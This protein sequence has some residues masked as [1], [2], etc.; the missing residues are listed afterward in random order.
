A[1][2]ANTNSFSDLSQAGWARNAVDTLLGADLI[3]GVGPGVFDPNADLTRAQFTTLL[4]KAD[5]LAPVASG[6]TPFADVAATA[7]YAPYVAAAYKAGL[8]A[9]VSPTSF[10]PNGDLTREQMVVMLAK[11]LGSS[12]P[13]GNLGRFTDASSIAPWARSGVAAT[14]GAGLMSGYPDGAF[15]PTGISTRAQAA[16]VLA[17]YLAY[18]GKV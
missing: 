10:D 1:V 17:Q 3:A 11:L 6:A 13:S 5:G 7:W 8:V 14:V 4:V 2:F 15:R 9:G 12:A 16:A 18:V